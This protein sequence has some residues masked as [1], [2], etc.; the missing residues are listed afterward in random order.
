MKLPIRG[1][2]ITKRN[3]YGIIKRDYYFNKITMSEEVNATNSAVELAKDNDN[4]IDLSEVEGTG[5]N[6]RILK[7]DVEALLEE[8]EDESDDNKEDVTANEPKTE[9]DDGS[10]DENK[11]DAES[12]PKK[13]EP[14]SLS[15]SFR[16][17]TKEG[18]RIQFVFNGSGKDLKEAIKKLKCVAPIEEEGKDF[19]N[20]I[21][22]LVNATVK[23]G[24]HEFSRALAPHVARA[25]LSNQKNTEYLEKLLGL[26]K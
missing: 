13:S 2:W 22:L 11:K 4:D 8:D 19:P 1:L 25:T 26:R 17:R 14:V 3:K 10:N 23:R 18:D 16:V 7:G 5:E 20:G 6:G 15:T 21:N 12:T 9:S 24:D